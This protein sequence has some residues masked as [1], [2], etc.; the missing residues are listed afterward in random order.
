M[1]I[2]GVCSTDTLTDTVAV[3]IQLPVPIP[4]TV[5]TFVA[6]GVKATPF[7]TPLLQVNVGVPLAVNITGLPKQIVVADAD[8][9][10]SRVTTETEKVCPPAA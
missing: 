1:Q 6:V 3:L 5:Y 7:E 8:A 10:I 9:L 2:S 4:E